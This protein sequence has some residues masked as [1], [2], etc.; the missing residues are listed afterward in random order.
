[1]IETLLIVYLTGLVVSTGYFIKTEKFNPNE[2]FVKA[3]VWPKTWY[4]EFKKKD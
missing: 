4:E 2:R 3:L 1:M